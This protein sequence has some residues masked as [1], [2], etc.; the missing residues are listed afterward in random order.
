MS[1]SAEISVGGILYCCINFGYQK[2]LDKGDGCQ[3]FPSEFLCLTMPKVSVGEY[4]TVALISGTG[5]VWIRWGSEYQDF[6]SEIF[7]LTV[8][9]KFVGEPFC[10]PGKFWCRKL[11]G[12]R[13]G[14]NITT[15]RRNFLSHSA[16]KVRGGTL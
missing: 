11:L 15:S 6:P 1:H 14:A 4:F 16:E 8:W 7:C 13:E 10:V 9:K 5:K 2:S 3:V 12:T